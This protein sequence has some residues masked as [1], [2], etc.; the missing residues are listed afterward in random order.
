MKP[1]QTQ[2]RRDY[3]WNTA[4]SLMNSLSAVVMLMI[5]SRV[6]DV[7]TAGVFAFAFALGQQFQTLGIYEVRTFHITDVNML[8]GFNTY[9]ATRVITTFLMIVGICLYS[10]IAYSFTQG[11]ILVILIASL[12]VY[13]SAEDV[14]V[15]EFQRIGKLDLAARANFFRM[16]FTTLSLGV[17]LIVTHDL[18]LS[19]ISSLIIS[20]IVFIIVYIPLSA[21]HFSLKITWRFDEIKVVLIECFPIFVASFLAMFIANA[22]RYAIDFY[23]DQKAQGYFA[24]IFMPAVT[25]NLFSLFVFRP[26]MVPL[27]KNWVN[28]KLADFLT[29][30]KKG[31]LASIIAFAAVLVVTVVAG[32][33]ILKL[34]FGQ[35]VSHLLV[36]L[37]VLVIAGAGNALSIIFYYSLV[38]IRKQNYAF[39]GFFSAAIT[40]VILSIVFIPS[41]QL[42]GACIAYAIAMLVLNLVFFAFLKMSINQKKES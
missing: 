9:A 21:R 42:L 33:P 14:I 38:T 7:T 6:A 3:F 2:L 40:V 12:R 25:I 20:L 32:P 8:F 39:Y 30:I 27:A 24:I 22:P 29:I 16:L 41:M 1:S 18:L 35:D 31:V 15:S 28:N 37:V 13:D 5:V 34:V 17:A 10:F 36:E 4:A 26:L 19:T 11:A 23:L